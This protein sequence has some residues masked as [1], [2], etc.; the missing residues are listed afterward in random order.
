MEVLESGSNI[1]KGHRNS[2]GRH[3]LWQILGSTG[4][5]NT[6]I[7]PTPEKILLAFKTQL[8]T[9]KWQVNLEVSVMRVL[10]GFV[11]DSLSG[12][13]VGILT[14]IFHKFERA[15]AVIFGLIRSIPMM[16]LVPLFI[17]WCG[18]GESSK[19][20]VIAIGTF[21][22]VFLNTQQGIETRTI[23]YGR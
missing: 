9:G 6:S 22:S 16:G 11:I 17:L 10:I 20:T 21:W 18:I 19:I 8:R 2:K 14:G 23:Y 4:H 7:L 13:I 15:V 12:V 1:F 3:C 5:L